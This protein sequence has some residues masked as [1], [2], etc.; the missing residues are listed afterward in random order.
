MK[1]LIS[2]DLQIIECL[3]F[4]EKN[5]Q[6]LERKGLNLTRV[7]SFMYIYVTSFAYKPNMKSYIC[8]K[9]V[10]STTLLNKRG[11]CRSYK[12][13]ANNGLPIM[14]AAKRTKNEF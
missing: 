12:H 4:L 3:L 11:Y 6:N 10:V 14:Q 7:R 8:F 5:E 9:I 1:S 13:K 2:S